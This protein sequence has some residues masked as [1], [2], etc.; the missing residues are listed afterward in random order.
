V[1]VCVCVCVCMCVYVCVCVCLCLWHAACKVR[2]PVCVCQ[3]VFVC[4]CVPSHRFV[5]HSCACELVCVYLYTNICN[6][7]GA[8]LE[9]C[10]PISHVERVRLALC[11][12]W[13]S[14]RQRAGNV[15]S[16]L[17]Y[18]HMYMYMYTYIYISAM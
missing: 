7:T 13:H 4:V 6:H 16:C 10:V 8:V 9:A 14:G 1:C 2:T 15:Y 3:R 17:Y 11:Q 12:R 18:V 5:V